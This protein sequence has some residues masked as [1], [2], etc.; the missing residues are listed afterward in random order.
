MIQKIIFLFAMSSSLAFAGTNSS[1]PNSPQVETASNSAP[2]EGPQ[3]TMLLSVLVA[4]QKETLAAIRIQN[5]Q[6]KEQNN[7]LRVQLTLLQSIA[8]ESSKR[9]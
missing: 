1:Q 7:L 8:L 9:Q 6:L 5:D 3:T 4:Q 2:N